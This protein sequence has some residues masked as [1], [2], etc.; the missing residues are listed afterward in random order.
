[1]K[2]DDLKEKLGL[3]KKEKDPNDPYDIKGRQEKLDNKETKIT[4]FSYDAVNDCYVWDEWDKKKMKEVRMDAVHITGKKN[5]WFETDI[6]PEL[7][8]PKE[9][10]SAI[11]LYL[12]T[13]NEKMD[14]D[15][16]SEKGRIATDFDWKKILMIAGA[17]I[18]IIILVPMFIK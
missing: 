16:I 6:W 2:W 10:Q 5:S 15:K 4:Y 8:W 1:M 12:W 18:I 7:K 9:G 13:I 3:K 17:V 14:P 11:H